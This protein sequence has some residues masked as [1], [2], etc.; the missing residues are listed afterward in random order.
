MKSREASL[1]LLTV[2]VPTVVTVLKH[3]RFLAGEPGWNLAA[4]LQD[5]PVE[6]AELGRSGVLVALAFSSR[7]LMGLCSVLGPWAWADRDLRR[8]AVIVRHREGM[9]QLRAVGPIA[10]KGPSFLAVRALAHVQVEHLGPPREPIWQQSMH[11]Y[12]IN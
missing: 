9:P 12:F 3:P 10:R 8:A 11:H 7:T 2:P 5:V 6:R 1:G 4:A